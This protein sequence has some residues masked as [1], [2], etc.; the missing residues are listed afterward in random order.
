[1]MGAN[2]GQLQGIKVSK[3]DRPW[4]GGTFEQVRQSDCYRFD[5]ESIARKGTFVIAG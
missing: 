2:A 3:A 1:M 5:P 4:K